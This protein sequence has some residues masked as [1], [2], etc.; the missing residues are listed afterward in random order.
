VRPDASA[1]TTLLSILETFSQTLTFSNYPTWT[2][3]L[4]SGASATGLT[5]EIFDGSTN[6]LLAAATGSG[7][8]PATFQFYTPGT[9]TIAAGHPY[10]IVLISGSNLNL[11]FKPNGN[12]SAFTYA[13]SY[14]ETFVRP[15]L[16]VLPTPNPNPTY[17][18]TVTAHVAVTVTVQNPA[19]TAA[20]T[21]VP[22]GTV[23]FHAVETDVYSSNPKTL[24]TTSDSF[25]DFVPSGA[26]TSVQQVA[27][28]STTSD[29][30]AF[31]TIYPAGT[32]LLDVLPESAGTLTANTAAV[33]KTET[34]TDGQSST[35]TYNAD[36]TYSES[37]IFPGGYTGTATIDATGKG[38]I[39]A[40]LEALTNPNTII[41]FSAPTGPA[42]SGTITA[43]ITYNPNLAAPS[44]RVYGNFYPSPLVFWSQTFVNNGSV[45]IPTSC[46]VP[47]TLT[48]PANQVVQTSKNI[49]TAF[50]EIETVQTTNYNVQGLGTVCTVLS[51]Q[52]AQYYDY[53]GQTVR[54]IY[55][56]YT[57]T[58]APIPI[59]TTSIAETI[60]MQSA[61]IVGTTSLSARSSLGI[62]VAH[63]A[64][65]NFAVQVE[66]RRLERH[67][68]L[69]RSA[70]SP[71]RSTH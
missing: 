1:P 21:T 62:A 37:D 65:A 13:G 8:S 38:T 12:G 35:R 43:V 41:N 4:P 16:T 20:P 59:Q 33:V 9:W 67:T 58:A 68:S 60:G 14:V 15:P 27:T 47:S 40:P 10:L 69:L 50:G 22:A 29:G 39:S 23:D 61:N 24:V 57:G 71:S 32:G 36:G 17:S 66:K 28:S 3:G 5:L 25:V 56:P 45:V 2:I 54:L 51:D 34:N 19:A 48:G 52:I 18:A 11:S 55:T 46:N 31:Q 64:A 70:L 44:T 30:A 63:A 7:S 6:A 42:P 26:L 49:D 53:S